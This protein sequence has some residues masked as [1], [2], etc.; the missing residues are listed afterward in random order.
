[1]DIITYIPD[2]DAF[3]LEAATNASNGV[4]GFSFNDDG[5]MSYDIAKIPVYYNSD[6]VRSI[7][8]I[9]LVTDLEL[10]T[11]NSLVSCEKI[12][13]C[14]NKIYTFDD[15]GE[16]IYNDVYDQAPV[17]LGEGVMYTPPQMIGVFA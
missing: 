15:G 8:L 3:R 1:M 10:K 16:D 14:E 13:V 2:L 9:R 6:G 7:C 17:D 4:K 12:G 11:F 5:A